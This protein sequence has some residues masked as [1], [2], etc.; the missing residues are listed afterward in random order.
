MASSKK[1][2]K[3]GSRQGLALWL[4]IALLVLLIDQF[5]KVLVLGAFQLGDSTAVTSFFNLVRAHNH[6]AAFSFLAAAGG[7]QR[8]FFTGI[9]VVAAVFMLWMLRSHAGQKLFSLAIALI[10]GG[11]IG[12]V[13]DRLL[14]GYVIDFLDFFWGS[15][16]FPAFNVADSAISLGAVL[17]ILDEILRVR[18]GR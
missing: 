16:H 13:V 4:G 9:G 2:A 11:A 3:S 14:H 5:T 17:L 10:L 1:F 7:W 12:N 6:G 18:R 15:W 8:W